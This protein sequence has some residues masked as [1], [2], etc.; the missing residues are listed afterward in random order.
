MDN[1]YADAKTEW[2]DW[3]ANT[4]FNTGLAKAKGTPGIQARSRNAEFQTAASRPHMEP[5]RFTDQM[6]ARA[7]HAGKQYAGV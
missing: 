6:L 7:C 4:A 3:N 1:E 5:G 2:S